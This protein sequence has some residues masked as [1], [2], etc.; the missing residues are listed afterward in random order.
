MKTTSQT[1]HSRHKNIKK[2]TRHIHTKPI[3]QK[4]RQKPIYP[5]MHI[6]QKKVFST[7]VKEELKEIEKQPP[8]KL[9]SFKEAYAIL[10]EKLKDPRVIPEVEL[11]V[12][13]TQLMSMEVLIDQTLPKLTP[14]ERNQLAIKHLKKKLLI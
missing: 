12:I 14:E 10:N 7:E 13:R 4:L 1:R 11:N 3:S 6:Q 2:P 8:T 9:P 5:S